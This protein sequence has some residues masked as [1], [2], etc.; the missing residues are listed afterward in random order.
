M[1]PTLLLLLAFAASSLAPPAAPAEGV[2]V[3]AH[4]DPPAMW[5][6]DHVTYTLEIACPA[7]VDIVPEDL[8]RSKLSLTGL[9]L[10]SADMRRRQEG[11]A[12][13]YTFEYVSTTYRVD[14]AT[15]E[16]GG[17]RVHYFLTRAGQRAQ[18]AAPAGTITIPPT[19]IA[20]RSLLADDQTAY[21]M[22]EGGEVPPRSLPYR[23]LTPVGMALIL[24]SIVPAALVVVRAVYAA[25]RLRRAERRPSARRARQAAR[26]TL[27]AIRATHAEDPGARRTGFTRLESLVRGHLAAVAGPEFEALTAD[28]I[29]E[30]GTAGHPQVAWEL[31]T[32]VIESCEIARFGGLDVQPSADVWRKALDDAGV[33]LGVAPEGR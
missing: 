13:R 29:R 8:D 31:V 10:V 28:E 18:D 12:V 33:I 5:V 30:A 1:R 15:P 2:I 17:M 22:R 20:F 21:Q 7:G 14:V 16:I 6:A 25:R 11:A 26:E 19:A 27:E 4:V 24:I 23:L 3:R 32:S 9:D